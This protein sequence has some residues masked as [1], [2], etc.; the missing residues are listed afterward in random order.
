MQHSKTIFTIDL[1]G[2]DALSNAA[3][4]ADCSRVELVA[5]N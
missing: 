1:I 4:V 2:G 5:L 3:C